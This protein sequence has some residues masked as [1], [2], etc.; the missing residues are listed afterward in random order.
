MFDPSVA[1][2]MSLSQT[3]TLPQDQTLQFDL[4]TGAVTGVSIVRS[5]YKNAAVI[6]GFKQKIVT[7]ANYELCF[8]NTWNKSAPASFGPTSR[9][10][11]PRY[12]GTLALTFAQPLLRN[13]GTA[14]NT[15]PI[16]QAQHAEEI[17]R[18]RLVQTILDTVFAVQQGYWEL[19]FGIQ[20]LRVRHEARNSRRISWQKIHSVWP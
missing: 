5:F 6:P 19:V 18:Q 20:D 4:Q 8:M 2:T 10:T 17:A 9:L 12:E 1:L 11:N 13:F 16:R 3:K 7:G 14:V 15:A